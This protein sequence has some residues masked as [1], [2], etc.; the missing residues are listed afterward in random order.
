ME[1]GAYCP[2]LF[3]IV[4]FNPVAVGVLKIELFYAIDPVGDGIL[5]PCPIL[6]F[7][8]VLF[9]VSDKIVDGRNAET[10]VGVLVVRRFG[11]S[12]GNNM[13]VAGCAEAK[14]GMAAIVKRLGN[15]IET[16]HLLIEMGADLQ[17]HYV[18]GDVVYA[19]FI[20]GAGLQK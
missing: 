3:I 5:L 18:Q 1:S 14:P 13:Q 8:F 15:G 9:K 12:A 6:V 20:L 19:R 10:K 17:V 16:D 11:S 7:N 4:Y 2:G